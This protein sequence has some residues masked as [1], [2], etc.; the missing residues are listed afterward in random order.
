MAR[1]AWLVGVS[2]LAIAVAALT[3]SPTRA[4]TLKVDFGVSDDEEDPSP[5]NPNDVYAGYFDYSAPQT[6]Q[7]Q[8]GDVAYLPLTGTTRS[9][10]GISVTLSV[11]PSGIE[12]GLH[13][14]FDVS[15]S[16]GNLIEDVAWAARS[17]LIITLSGLP[18]A[19]YQWTSYHHTPSPDVGWLGPL[20]ILADTGAGLA[21]KVSNLNPTFSGSNIATA[22]FPL[23]ANGTSDVI[24]R[25]HGSTPDAFVTYTNGFT[26]VPVPEPN[27]PVLIATGVLALTMHR[28]RRWL[29][30]APRDEHRRAL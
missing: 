10:S 25:I 7:W 24:M 5:T 29:Q 21:T 30:R 6:N 23:V 13:D 17:D 27:T 28:F 22:S 26:L 15:G 3:P 12:L 1:N 8:N 19:T 4:V 9:V 18:A 2:A 20:D 16:L 11:D 14:S